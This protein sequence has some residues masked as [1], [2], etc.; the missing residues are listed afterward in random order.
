MLLFIPVGF[1]IV[2]VRR[3][4]VRRVPATL[5]AAALAVTLAAGK[6]LFYGRHAAVADI[7]AESAGGLLGA[8]LAW[9]AARTARQNA[10][11]AERELDGRREAA[12][13]DPEREV[14]HGGRA[15]WQ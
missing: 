5:L 15:N 6:F 9:K 12:Y 11:G 8:V 10:W 3:P 1:L 4:P 14:R 13:A 2:F 7:V